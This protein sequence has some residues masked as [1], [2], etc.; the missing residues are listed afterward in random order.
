MTTTTT[1]PAYIVADLAIVENDR[2]YQ[3]TLFC[4]VTRPDTG[5]RGTADG[6][7]VR[8]GKRFIELW[9]NGQN[10]TVNKYGVWLAGLRPHARHLWCESSPLPK[11]SDQHEMARKLATSCER[12]TIGGM[13]ETLHTFK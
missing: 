3:D 9:I 10:Y 12:V 6:Y 5:R 1:P 8:R 11:L 7:I 2:A 13:S 4:P